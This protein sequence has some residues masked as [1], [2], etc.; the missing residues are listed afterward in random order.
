MIGKDDEVLA[1]RNQQSASGRKKFYPVS[2]IRFIH[3][4]FES[5][6]FFGIKY[7]REENPEILKY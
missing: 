5:T 1:G 7:L 2:A 3:L 6:Y 4:H